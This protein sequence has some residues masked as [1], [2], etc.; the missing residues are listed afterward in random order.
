[1]ALTLVCF[2]SGP[3]KKA[4]I[5]SLRRT[6]AAS[7]H[8]WAHDFLHHTTSE[9]LWEAAA[10]RK[11]CSIKHIP[12]LLVAPLRL[13]DDIIE[14]TEAFKQRFFVMDY[15]E[16]NPFQHDDP[17]PLPPRN[18]AP[19]TQSEIASAL[20]DTSNKSAP[21][22]SGINYQLL[23]WAFSSQPDR[24][25]TLFNAA[26]SLGHHPWS[27]ALV[28]VI[29]K[30]AKP[31]Y[32]LPKAYRP[33]SLLECC[34]KLLEKIIAKRILSDTHHFNILPPTQFGSHDYHCAVDAALCLVHNA[35]SAVQ[36]GYVASV[37]LFD[38]SGFFDNINVSRV[39]HIF[40][41]LGFPPS[42][43]NWILSFLTE[44][45]VV[46]SFN[47][48]KSLPIF[49]DHGTPQGSPLSPILSAIYTSPLLKFIN[50]NWSR[51]GL[52][53]YVDD[54]AIFSNTKTQKESARIAT[55]ALQEIT[56]WLGR[57]G[58]KCDTDKTEFI[59]FAPL[60][61]RYL[62]GAPVSSIQPCTS[63][64]S[65]YT[66]KHSSLIR[67][68]GIFIHERFDWTHHVTI[69]ANHARSTIH[70]LSILRNSVRGLDYAN[71]RQLFHSLIL[72]VLTYSFPLYSTQ[73][74]IKGL[75]DILQITQNDAVRKMSGAFKT[76]PVVPLHYLLAIPPLPLTIIK[77]TDVFRLRIKCLP[78]SHLIRTITTFNPAAAWFLSLRPSTC[79]MRLLPDPDSFPPFIYPSPTYKSTWTHPQVWDN[80]VYKL[81]P[82]TK[83]ATKYLI[84][85]PPSDTFNLFIRVLTIPS[86][87]FAAS[88]LLFWG[89]MLVHYG[90][91]R[92]SSRLRTLFSALC[93]GLMYALLSNHVRIFLPDL[94]LQ[95]YL[96]RSHKHPLLD[97][98]YSFL[99]LLSSFLSA[100]PV[101]HVDILRYSIKWSGLL[102]TAIVDTLSEEQQQ[103]VFADPPSSLLPKARLLLLIQEQYDLLR[104]DSCIW[105]SI[106]HPD[107]N[108]P[109]YIQGAISHKDR[110]TFS[111]AV[112][113][114]FD[115]AFTCTYS[116]IFRANAGD[117]LW[118][119]CHSTPPPSAPSSPT[120]E[121]AGFERLMVIQ[122]ANPRATYS[123][124]LPEHHFPVLSGI[125]QVDGGLP[126]G[127]VRGP[128][129]QTR[130]NTSC[131][132]APPSPLPITASLVATLS[133]RT[134]LARIT[135]P[136]PWATSNVPPTA[137]FA[138]CLPD[139]TLLDW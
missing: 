116:R 43:C 113:L 31:D 52:N 32:S 8:N 61:P 45:K 35:Q 47:G 123:L 41:N 107:G 49:L 89:Q 100:D 22:L 33:I 97:L 57:N 79:L 73:P 108:L 111:A 81:S 122:H 110:H 64:S 51:R 118:C 138:L 5:S 23:K 86:P 106:I 74:H 90:A 94:S 20:A 93:N 60:R 39:V 48:M 11:G 56:A 92:D 34:G 125:V 44:R 2:S 26:I 46:L 28:I 65:S 101:H 14:M 66:V 25:L 71:W 37:V 53:M 50:D 6:I 104:H 137:S 78:P 24:F 12:P 95:P 131:L 10:W 133:M 62:I 80:T 127:L 72:P 139:Q 91:T 58:L 13:S 120:S 114:A 82:A 96:F 136:L 124:T 30:P 42:L 88:F 67:Y 21:G 68:L 29:P 69:M 15:P 119:P 130:H 102:G 83:E 135:A 84:K 77:L 98:S 54:G 109:P 129:I 115:H 3:S 128:A 121:Q 36:A 55:L 40:R 4:A 75:L 76:T 19:I 1:M 63:A 134:S 126:C 17:P 27:D 59:T 7:K 38:I 132:S 9:N 112:Q 87:P 85:Q 18:F 103:L 105:Q 99:S 117:N 70:A 16:V